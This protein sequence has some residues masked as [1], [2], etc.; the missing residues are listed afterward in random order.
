MLQPFRICTQKV[1]AKLVVELFY[2]GGKEIMFDKDEL[3]IFN[4]GY[5]KSIDNLTKLLRN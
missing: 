1:L 3:D 5:K 2:D 4:N